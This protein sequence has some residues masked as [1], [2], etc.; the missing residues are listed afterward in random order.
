MNYKDEFDI[1]AR[2]K[3]SE[4]IKIKFPTRVPII[5]DR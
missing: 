2:K 3:E 5:C 1:D 4:R